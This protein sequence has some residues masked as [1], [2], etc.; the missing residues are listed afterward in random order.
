MARLVD[1]RQPRNVADLFSEGLQV[2]QREAEQ[3]QLTTVRATNLRSI[4][5]EQAQRRRRMSPEAMQ[6]LADISDPDKEIDADALGILAA[7]GLDDR[8]LDVR[9]T[10]IRSKNLLDEQRFKEEMWKV[11]REMLGTR[12][13]IAEIELQADQAKYA[14]D[15]QMAGFEAVEAVVDAAGKANKARFGGLVS[16]PGDIGQLRGQYANQIQNLIDR[17]ATDWELTDRGDVMFTDDEVATK[18][19]AAQALVDQLSQQ[20]PTTGEPLGGSYRRLQGVEIQKI[21]EDLGLPVNPNIPPVPRVPRDAT[22]RVRLGR[23]AEEPGAEVSPEVDMAEDEP[24]ESFMGKVVQGG[25][26]VAQAGKAAAGAMR[27]DREPTGAID[28]RALRR[29]VRKQG[30]RL[31]GQDLELAILEEARRQKG[32]ALDAT[33]LAIVKKLLS[34]GN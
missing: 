27:P 30:R 16:E 14:H 26:K 9:N 33:D 19:R 34:K 12:K 31:A 23:K 7:A 2:A 10:L 21:V 5:Q 28:E 24:G 18:I 29:S 13:T 6:A 4:M 32:A 3:E 1:L 17:D 25:R 20:D 8:A 15:Q 11:E 22:G